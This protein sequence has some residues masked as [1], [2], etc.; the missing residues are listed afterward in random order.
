MLK[1]LARLWQQLQKP[2]PPSDPPSLARVWRMLRAPALPPDP[3]QGPP[4]LR[5]GCRQC[6]QSFHQTVQQVYLALES[7][8]RYQQTGWLNLL[9]EEVSIPETIVCP[10][11]G[12][13]NQFYLDSY[14]RLWVAQQRFADGQPYGPDEPI[15]FIHMPPPE[16]NDRPVE[17]PKRRPPRKKGGKAGKFGAGMLK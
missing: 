12:A 4:H 2:L 6:H 9:P 13:A 8:E 1:T 7:I 17:R 5:F 14:A 16:A 3:L 10:H 11:C 15:Q